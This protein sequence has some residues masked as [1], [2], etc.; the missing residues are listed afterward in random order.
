MNKNPSNR[1]TSFLSD[2]SSNYYWRLIESSK[3]SLYIINGKTGKFEYTSPAITTITGFT[4]KEIIQM[5]VEGINKKVH[6][7]DQWAMEETKDILANKTLSQNSHS[8]T[9]LRFKHKAGRYLWLGISRNFITDDNGEIEAIVGCVRDITETKLLQ[10]QLKSTLDDY[11][12]LYNNARV[13][14]YRTRINDGKVLEC[15]E[16]MA[17]LLGYKNREQCLAQC[18]TTK[19]AD[20]EGRSEFIRLLKEKGQIDGFELKA[21]RI[22]GEEFWIKISAKICPEEGY[23][24]GAAWDITASKLLTPAENKIL[25]LIMQGKSSKGIAFQLKRSIRT[26]EDHRAHIMQKLGTH[27]LVELTKKVMDSWIER[28]KK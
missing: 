3:D 14:L 26:I 16:A 4:P 13:A 20:P 21:R 23:I 10:Q 8:Y 5:G 19:H 9:E 2:K 28:E 11:K 6:P 22:S 1:R 7:D 12:S 15:S 25:E 18:Y 24:E 27:N 17:K